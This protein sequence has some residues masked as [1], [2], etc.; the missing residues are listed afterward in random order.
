MTDQE[1]IF[2]KSRVRNVSDSTIFHGL[3][4]FFSRFFFFLNS[5]AAPSGMSGILNPQPG[6]EPEPLAVETWSPNCWTT[7]EVHVLCFTYQ[8]L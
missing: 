3:V 8:E 4:F 6:I 2:Y 7:R 5:L 1:L